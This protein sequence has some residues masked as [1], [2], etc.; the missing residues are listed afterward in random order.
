MKLNRPRDKPPCLTV[1]Q[2]DGTDVRVADAATWLGAPRPIGGG[3]RAG[4][5]DDN[6]SIV[7]RGC[8]GLI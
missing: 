1:G 4:H 8:P 6:M 5:S 2:F 3:C 7:A